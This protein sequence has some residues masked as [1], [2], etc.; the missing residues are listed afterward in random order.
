MKHSFQNETVGPGCEH[1]NR[2][3][4]RLRQLI[5]KEND[6]LDRTYFFETIS[7]LDRLTLDFSQYWLENVDIDDLKT[8]A[9]FNP[10]IQSFALVD[11]FNMHVWLVIQAELENLRSIS[12][13]H[14]RLLISSI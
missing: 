5:F 13:L 4:L 14:L 3:V 9:T 2:L 12:I 10:P 6:I 11:Y 7:N 1:F 8:I